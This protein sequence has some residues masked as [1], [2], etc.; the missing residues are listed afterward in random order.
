MPNTTPSPAFYVTIKPRVLAARNRWQRRDEDATMWIRNAVVLVLTAVIIVG[1]YSATL[2]VLQQTHT[3][4][5]FAYLHP[6]LFLGLILVFLF[7]MLLVTNLASALGALFMSRDLGLILASPLSSRRF[8]VGKWLEVMISSSWMTL[9]FLLPV[10]VAFGVFFGGGMRYAVYGIL[11][12]LPYFAIPALMAMCIATLIAAFIPANRKR[13]LMALVGVMSLAALYWLTR[14]AVFTINDGTPIDFTDVLRIVSFLSITN[15]AWSPSHWVANCLGELLVPGGQPLGVYV[16]LL[17]AVTTAFFAL[18]F[19]I[20]RLLHFEGFSRAALGKK[21]SKLDSRK[22]H[23]RYSRV[24]SFLDEPTRA[25]LIKEAKST[26]RDITQSVQCILL[27]GLS[28]L[29]VYLLNFQHLFQQAL[30]I[31]EERWWRMFLI[32]TNICL[33]AFVITAMA[34]RMVFPSISREGQSYWV[35]QSA[36][37]DSRT[38]LRVKLLT[39]LIPIALITSVIFGASSIILY[40]SGW[41]A[42]LKIAFNVVQCV[43]LLGMAIGFGCYFVDFNWEHPS[44]LIASFGSMIY[45]VTAVVVILV[46][47]GF[48]A[49]V[50]G[51]TR[52]YA[53]EVTPES[54]AYLGGALVVS[55]LLVLFNLGLARY[56]IRWGERSLAAYDQR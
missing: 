52:P 20:V 53:R 7:G 15:V 45:M 43:G 32:I 3:Q 5:D 31:S 23:Q 22:S 9:V 39:W 30:P 4:L 55:L 48:S 50:V 19:I 14:L 2:W 26:S 1:C 21:S 25:V 33:E 42:L 38:F 36:P 49:V 27:L 17:Y 13:E 29:Y 18:A 56:S 41:I 11:V 46:N 37:I 24:L 10:I 6:R 54:L 51:L 28:A 44:E 40:K 34:T 35:L 12:L 16:V 8:F 47:L